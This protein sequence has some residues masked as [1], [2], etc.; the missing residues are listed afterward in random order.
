MQMSILPHKSQCI[1]LC[2]I[3]QENFVG[4]ETLKR[5]LKLFGSLKEELIL[6]SIDSK[7]WIA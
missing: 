3:N 4:R 6:I 2:K 1:S 7:N 5:A